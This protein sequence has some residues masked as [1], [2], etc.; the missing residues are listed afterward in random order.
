M[1]RATIDSRLIFERRAIAWRYAKI[2]LVLDFALVAPDLTVLVL[3][4]SL[5]V[6]CSGG[7]RLVRLLRFM[8]KL[9]SACFVTRLRLS[10]QAFE[11]NCGDGCRRRERCQ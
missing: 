9:M 4:L 10:S 6:A 5:D 1:S 3:L 2:W 8:D 7:F 11:R